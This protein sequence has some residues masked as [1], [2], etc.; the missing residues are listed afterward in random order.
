MSSSEIGDVKLGVLQEVQVTTTTGA[1]L[2]QENGNTNVT[3]REKISEK[4]YARQVQDEATLAVFGKK[5]QL[6]RRFKSLSSVGLTCG[7]M[8]TWEVILFTLQFGLQN[9]GPAGLIYGYLAAWAGSMLQALVMAE[10][11]S[12]IPLAGGPFNWVAILSPPWCKKFLSY[13][14]G[15]L[16]VICWQAFVA[17]TCY[18]V[19]SLIQGLLILNY[20]DYDPKLWQATLLFYAIAL[21]GAFINTYL[22]GLLPRIEAMMLI[23]YILGFIGVL[24]P[25]VYLSP[26]SSAEKVFTTFQNLGGWNS[27]GLSFFVGWITSVS[28][29]VGNDGADHIAEEINQASK[30]IPF[31][32][33][34]STLFNGMLGFS[35]MIAVL[36]SV[37]D[38]VAATQSSTGFPFMEI[39][40][41]A[42]GS[43]KGANALVDPKTRLP[44]NAII[45]T[46][47]VNVLLA[48]VSV[49]SYTAFEAFYSV[50]LAA[51]QSSF[52]LAASV[53]L[54]KRLKTPASEMPWGPF[55][56]RKLGVPI[57]IVAMIYT[58]I[59][60]FFSFWPAFSTVDAA[61][62]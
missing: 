18:T 43:K 57:T 27:M 12:M 2:D 6:K 16:T 30:V 44:I 46:L 4:D 42:L 17:E 49:G 32:I 53:M 31:S 38:I 28:S 29:F 19:A 61:V 48:L 55:R 9:G 5:Q 56:L 13:L 40:Q 14:A 47:I 33:W 7:L 35:M 23:V 15:W 25:L 58:V 39:F 45:G 34:F 24:I 8:L 20:P 60:L 26:H 51:Y 37:Q 54:V 21:F 36:F 62:L 52:L 50:V 10:M 1:D 11:S 41:T 22:G 59:A 3:E